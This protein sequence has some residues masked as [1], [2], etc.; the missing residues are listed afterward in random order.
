MPETTCFICT[1]VVA[2]AALLDAEYC[3]DAFHGGGSGLQLKVCTQH[4]TVHDEHAYP[5]S[6]TLGVGHSAPL[7]ISPCT[8]LEAPSIGSLAPDFIHHGPFLKEK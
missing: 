5:S 2:T 8:T 6:R 4:P 7:R 3:V 1:A